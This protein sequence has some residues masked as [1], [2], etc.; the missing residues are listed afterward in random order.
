MKHDPVNHPRHYCGHPSGIECIAIAE[1][2]NFCLGNSF[3]YL[4]RCGDKGSA[5]EDL[6]KALWYADRELER[7]WT[8]KWRWNR[9]E[10]HPR[11]DCNETVQQVL[12]HE[13]RYNGHMAAAMGWICGASVCK[14]DITML[15]SAI[16]SIRRMISIAEWKEGQ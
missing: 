5:I 13:F 3:K 12:N 16:G 1:K 4:F 6:R 2:M 15:D 10:F 9:S 8:F 14:R 7:R 11:F